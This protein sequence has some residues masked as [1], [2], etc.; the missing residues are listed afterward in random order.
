MSEHFSDDASEITAQAADWLQ[1]RE[2]WNWNEADQAALVSGLDQSVS[3][4]FAYS[5]LV[6]AWCRTARVAL[7][8]NAAIGT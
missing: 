7:A 5:R 4:S 8:V 3:H 6:A 1:R 2:F